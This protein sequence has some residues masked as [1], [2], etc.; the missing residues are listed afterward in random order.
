M[1]AKYSIYTPFGFI[2]AMMR[3]GD[4]IDIACQS[5]LVGMGWGISAV[6]ADPA[7]VKDPVY[8]PTGQLT[9]FYSRHHGNRL[10]KTDAVGVPTYEQ[11]YRMGGITPKKKVAM[12]DLIATADITAVY[13]HAINRSFDKAIEASVD[14]SGFEPADRA[15]HH[16][17]LGRLNDAPETGQPEQIGRETKRKIADSLKPLR[18]IL[19]KRSVSCVEI[20][21]AR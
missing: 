17:I 19:P 15:I 6:H 1:V 14:L 10:L 12:I 16:L 20:P 3:C 7:A 2:H 5:M 9:A 21:L 8:L 4:A 11:P 18:V 13:V